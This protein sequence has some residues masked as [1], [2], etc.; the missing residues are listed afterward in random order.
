MKVKWTC[1][2]LSCVQLFATPWTVAF[3]AT[4]PWNSPGK[5]TGVGFHFLLQGIFSP[6]GSNPGLSHCRQ[7]LY[8]LSYLGSL[9]RACCLPIRELNSGL[10][11]HRWG[12]THHYTK[13][14]GDLITRRETRRQCHTQTNS[15]T[16][17]QSSHLFF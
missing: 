16:N 4:C 6:Q 5:N 11:Q 7:I 12:Y 15:V 2:L 9:K 1:W 14:V 10:P 13:E 8:N 17:Y 3:Q